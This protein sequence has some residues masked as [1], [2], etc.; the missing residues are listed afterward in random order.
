MGCLMG[1]SGSGC[2]LATGAGLATAGLALNLEDEAAFG[3]SGVI[4]GIATA[5]F[6]FVLAGSGAGVATLAAAALFAAPAGAFA[7]P[8]AACVRDLA[9]VT[10]L[11]GAAALPV[12]FLALLDSGL[13]AGFLA[14]VATIDSSVCDTAL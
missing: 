9:G 4:A 6:A 7:L 2:D 3:F 10:D 14:A 11:T 13:L 5:G 12:G 1:F 8:A